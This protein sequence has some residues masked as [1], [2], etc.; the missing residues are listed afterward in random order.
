MMCLVNFV[1]FL[2]CNHQVL[3]YFFL[4]F[5]HI[6]WPTIPLFFSVLHKT[7][8]TK[9]VVTIPSF[10]FKVFQPYYHSSVIHFLLQYCLFSLILFCQVLR[11]ELNPIDSNVRQLQ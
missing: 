1:L 6:H 2:V 7:K 9:T 3:I 11:E 8:V 10:T 4:T 5:L